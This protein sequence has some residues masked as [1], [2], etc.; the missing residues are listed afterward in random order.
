MKKI[1]LIIL[2]V[3]LVAFGNVSATTVYAGIPTGFDVEDEEE[4]EDE[5]TSNFNP[6]TPTEDEGEESDYF[7]P[8]P[9]RVITPE[10]GVS[11]DPFSFFYQEK[12]EIM[13]YR[14]G[15]RTDCSSGVCVEYFDYDYL[16]EG[17]GMTYLRNDILG[18]INDFE[19]QFSH[20][21]PFTFSRTLFQDTEIYEAL[22]GLLNSLIERANDGEFLTEEELES[23]E[24]DIND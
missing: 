5:K 10:R 1:F 19:T 9:V 21:N 23:I 24:E 22:I 13:K 20:S 17:D 11:E 12:E 8:E 2:M 3:S 7:K 15:W 6:E 4:K 16:L 18:R 14:S